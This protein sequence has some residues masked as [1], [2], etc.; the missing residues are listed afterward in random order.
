MTCVKMY[1][2]SAVQDYDG[3]TIDDAGRESWAFFLDCE[4]EGHGNGIA[5]ILSDARTIRDVAATLQFTL[6]DV[7]PCLDGLEIGHYA[8]SDAKAMHFREVKG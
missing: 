6:D 3:P 7:F 4:H 8:K 1:P 2:L 5:V